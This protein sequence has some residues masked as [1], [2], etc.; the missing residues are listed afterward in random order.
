VDVAEL[1]GHHNLFCRDMPEYPTFAW[2]E[3]IV[4]AVAHRDYADQGREIEVWFFDNRL[5]VLSPGDL[6]APV[7]LGHLQ[8]RRR[9]HASRN[10]LLT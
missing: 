5:E 9:I 4:N 7:T 1:I 8:A 3:A 10:P 6:V 2:Q